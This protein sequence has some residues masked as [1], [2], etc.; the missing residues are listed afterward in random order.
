MNFKDLDEAK[1]AVKNILKM[2]AEDII[3]G[4]NDGSFRPNKP[5]THAEAVVLTIRAAGLQSEIESQ[6]ADAVY[7][8]FKD[9]KSIPG[10]A[11]KAVAVAVEKG[12]LQV[13]K[14]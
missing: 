6:V 10:W 8:P 13:S 14:T 3:M 1:W 11:Q 7:L 9:A 4:Y 5:V 2:N 12:Y